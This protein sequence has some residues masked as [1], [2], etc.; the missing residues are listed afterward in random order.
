[1]RVSLSGGAPWLRCDSMSRFGLQS[2]SRTVHQCTLGRASRVNADSHRMVWKKL[3]YD[4]FDY[5]A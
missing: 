4:V 3:Q 2:G 5:P 1:M